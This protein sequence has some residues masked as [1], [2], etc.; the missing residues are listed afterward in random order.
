MMIRRYPGILLLLLLTGPVYALAQGG[1]ADQPKKDTT[2][3][4]TVV[5]GGEAPSVMPHLDTSIVAPP[6][7]EGAA[8]AQQAPVLR[9][10]PDTM[11]YRR[12][13][14]PKFAY[15]NE[16]EYWRIRRQ[17]PSPFWAWLGTV[18]QSDGFKYTVLTLLGGLL[19]YAIV[20]IIMENNL[21]LFYRRAKRAK[22]GDEGSA[23]LPSEEDIDQQLRHFL[24]IGDRRQATRY[25][26]LKSLQLLGDRGLIRRHADTTNQQYQRQLNGTPQEPGFRFLTQA[27]EMV[28]YGDF[29][30]S[31]GSFQRLHQRFMDFF[32][33]LEA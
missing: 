23:G 7:S 30:L 13:H 9:R 25:L 14:D 15:A 20:R 3:A 1:R 17:K 24:G 12:Q 26:Y 19:L 31:E 4:D 5:V 22:S 27:Y 33:T 18:L 6:E 32:K 21:G 28:W 10:L 16:P 2:V 29:V 8:S 11:V